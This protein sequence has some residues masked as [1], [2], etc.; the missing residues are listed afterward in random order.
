[1]I[2]EKHKSGVIFSLGLLLLLLLNA[3]KTVAAIYRSI[4]LGFKGNPCLAAAGSAYSN[5]LLSRRSSSI[6]TGI[7]TGFAALGLVLEASFCIKLLFTGG[8]HELLAAFLTDKCPWKC[9]VV[10]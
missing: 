7:T 1:M 6:F 4:R 8:E 2:H 10:Y 9:N 5:K 3:C